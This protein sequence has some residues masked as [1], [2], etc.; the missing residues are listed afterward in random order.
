MAWG[1]FGEKKEFEIGRTGHLKLEIRNLRFEIESAEPGGR[2]PK[3]EAERRSGMPF[4]PPLRRGTAVQ[5]SFFC[6]GKRVQ[7]GPST[8]ED[9]GA[10]TLSIEQEAQPHEILQHHEPIAPSFSKERISRRSE[11]DESGMACQRLCE[12]VPLCGDVVLPDRRCA[13]APR[14]NWRIGQLW[15]TTR[16]LGSDSGSQAIDPGLCE[17]TSSLATISEFVL[18][19]AGPMSVGD[20]KQNK[21]CV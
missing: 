8:V 14:D 12:L 21:I 9:R 15:G 3:F 18:P 17:S 5:I 1:R 11:E 13:I 6:W 20:R 7:M 2:N 19:G 16:A 10:R 4:H